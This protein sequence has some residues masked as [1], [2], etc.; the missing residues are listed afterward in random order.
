MMYPYLT[1]DDG[2]VVHAIVRTEDGQL[3]ADGTVDIFRL[4]SND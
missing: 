3:L 2:T 4:D 1:L